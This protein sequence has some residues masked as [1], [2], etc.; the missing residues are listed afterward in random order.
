[1]VKWLVTLLLCFAPLVCVAA[2]PK[3]LDEAAVIRIVTLLNRGKV[4]GLRVALIQEGTVRKDSFEFAHVRRVTFV[5][6]V[7]ENGSRV[8]RVTCRDFYWNEAY[9]WYVWETRQERGGDAV[10]IWSELQGEVV[11]R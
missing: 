8:R 3:E 4:S 6:P 1:M 10:W 7:A 5:E 2:P 11:V 9:G